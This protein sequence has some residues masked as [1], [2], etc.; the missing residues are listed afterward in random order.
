VVVAVVAVVVVLII[1]S[2][3]S[4]SDS[5][6]DSTTRLSLS[7]FWIARIQFQLTHQKNH[8]L[9]ILILTTSTILPFPLPTF[10]IYP[11][12]TYF[13]LLY[14]TLKGKSTLLNLI[15]SKGGL[16]PWEGIVKV[17]PSL[18]I[19]IFTQHHMDSFDLNKSAIQNLCAKWPLVSEQVIRTHLGK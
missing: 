13:T 18:R 1:T 14:S 2:C 9:L 5:D 6:S 7:L 16:T 8:P 3:E 10:P 17:N 11:Y 4:D 19:G 12:L 15:Q